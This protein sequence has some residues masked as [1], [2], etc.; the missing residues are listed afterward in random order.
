MRE[1]NLGLGTSSGEAEKRKGRAAKGSQRKP[2]EAKGSLQYRKASLR[3]GYCVQPRGYC[4]QE[5]SFRMSNPPPPST[6][7]KRGWAQGTVGWGVQGTFG[8]GDR[9]DG[10]SAKI[11][12]GNLGVCLS[13]YKRPTSAPPSVDSNIKDERGRWVKPSKALDNDFEEKL[14][15]K[16][17]QQEPTPSEP[18]SPESKQKE[19]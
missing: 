6:T 12:K 7:E 19:T 13:A 14:Y 3:A 8:G 9:D 17:A 2:K 5:N 10:S 15:N 16:S 18:Y 1:F 4:P 11:K